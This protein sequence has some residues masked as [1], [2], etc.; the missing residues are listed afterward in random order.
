MRSTKTRRCNNHQ[1]IAWNSAFD[2]IVLTPCSWVILDFMIRSQFSSKA[3]NKRI[4]WDVT[5]GLKSI[6]FW[7]FDCLI[8]YSHFFHF[9][10]TFCQKR[11]SCL[12]LLNRLELEQVF[13]LWQG[14]YCRLESH[15]LCFS[16]VASCCYCVLQQ[17]CLTQ[18]PIDQRYP[19][20]VSLIRGFLILK[21]S[22]NWS[23][24]LLLQSFQKSPQ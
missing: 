4:L 6:C 20:D 10:I 23:T 24:V 1:M 5:N 7:K 11:F 9:K 15:L 16:G 18:L 17:L 3:S 21:S 22:P 12:N 19:L 8:F 14:F 2:C 13:H